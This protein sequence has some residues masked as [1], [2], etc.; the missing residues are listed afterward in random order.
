MHDENPDDHAGPDDPDDHAGHDHAADDRPPVD[1]EV[2]AARRARLAA[3]LDAITVE[4][5]NAHLKTAPVQ[6]RQALMKRLSVRLDPKFIKGGIAR[7][8]RTRLRTLSPDK[9]VEMAAELTAAIDQEAADF[10]GEEAFEQPTAEDLDRLVTHLIA[11]HRPVMIRTYL[12]CT[13]A[14]EAPVA[15]ELDRLLASDPRVAAV[16]AG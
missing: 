5:L 12:A 4:D 1:P 9:Q 16:T 14:A 6:V 8:I 11:S 15:D 10:L 7:L 13:A 3:A 2:A